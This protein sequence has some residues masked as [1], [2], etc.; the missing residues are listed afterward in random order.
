MGVARGTP[1]GVAVAG[2]ARL[3]YVVTATSTVPAGRW[4]AL[5]LDHSGI[6]S[7]GKPLPGRYRT[8]AAIEREALEID[9]AALQAD[10]GLVGNR[11]EV[12]GRGAGRDVYAGLGEVVHLVEGDHPDAMVTD[13]AEGPAPKAA[14]KASTFDRL[15]V[16]NA[17]C[18]AAQSSTSSGLGSLVQPVG[19][20]DSLRLRV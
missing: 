18:T 6:V 4:R 3:G 1:G 5:P 20:A 10:A 12:I 7:H 11:L 16:W 15:R 2:I 9:V 17:R 13:D 8:W 19:L 14:Y